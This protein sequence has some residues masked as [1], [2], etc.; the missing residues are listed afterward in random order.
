MNKLISKNQKK[1]QTL[2]NLIPKSNLNTSLALDAGKVWR[3][4][5]G[6]PKLQTA[7][8]P[9]IDMLDYSFVDGRPAPPSDGQIK[10]IEL[11]NQL[12]VLLLFL[13][14]LFNNKNNFAFILNKRGKLL[15]V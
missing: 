15:E 12:A 4:S 5:A 10:R 9:L 7:R 11:Q 14:F 3:Q 8:G 13:F 6:L 1:I 2:I